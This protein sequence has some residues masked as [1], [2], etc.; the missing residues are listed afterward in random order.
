[1]PSLDALEKRYETRG[2][3][4]QTIKSLRN[5]YDIYEDE[6]KRIEKLPTVLV[7][8][9]DQFD[10]ASKSLAFLE[11]SEKQFPRDAG[12]LARDFLRSHDKNELS[13]GISLSGFLEAPENREIL[14]DPLEGEYFKNILWDLENV[15]R[16]EM[17]GLN[18]Y[19][20]P[21]GMSSR[22]FY[23]SSDTCISSI[24][25]MPRG[26]NL[27]CHA[28]FRSTNSEK[29]AAIDIE[30]LD[31]LVNVLGKKYFL[32]CKTYSIELKLNSA[33]ILEG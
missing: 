9:G 10:L 21:Q 15:I 11:S 8:R 6:V 20:K 2:D 1:M 18:P 25:L 31:F 14:S 29:N 12:I 3:A 19:G 5:L 33:H 4:I 22:R 23:Y 32:D 13:L 24:H 30:F 16:K 17:R 27:F 7:L 28:V 26:K